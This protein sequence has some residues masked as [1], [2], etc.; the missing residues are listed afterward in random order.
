MLGV[1]FCCVPFSEATGFFESDDVVSFRLDIPI[2]A[3]KKQ[4]GKETDWL[5]GKLFY[6]SPEKG[7]TTFNVK[8]EA[9]GNF[10]R[11]RSTC[12]FPPYWLNFK[13]S[14]VR[15]TFFDGLDKVKIVSHCNDTFRAYEQYVYT[16]Y[17]AYRTYNILTD[18]SFRVRPARITY[19]NTDRDREHGTYGAFFIEHVDSL[20]ERFEAVQV[21]D[22]FILPSRYDHRKLCVAEMF[23]F[24]LGNTDFSFFASEDECCHNGKAFEPLNNSDG[25]IAV[26]YDFDMSGLVHASYAEPD[27]HF[28]IPSVRHRLYRGIEVEHQILED[29]I[30]HYLRK[31]K[32]IYALWEETDLLEDKYRK[33]ALKYI[34]RFYK[35][36]DSDKTVSINITRNI[37]HFES[38]ENF[39]LEEMDK[40]AQKAAKRR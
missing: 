18:F 37:R 27:P 35:V 12:N 11:R 33:K 2:N 36:F 9:R 8:V 25:L 6:N 40:A 31:K 17:L 19:F 38:T 1:N 39:I 7:E 22:R 13:K 4:R 23:Q 21:K 15:G 34:D 24:F 32:A 28:E 16:E 29:T 26:P 5:E 20:E 30:R 14:E 10:R 3:L